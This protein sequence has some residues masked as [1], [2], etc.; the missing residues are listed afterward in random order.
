MILDSFKLYI[1]KMY[2]INARYKML[3]TAKDDY[4]EQNIVVIFPKEITYTTN[5]G[6]GI[7]GVELRGHLALYVTEDRKKEDFLFERMFIN[8]KDKKLN[9]TSN[10]SI[11]HWNEEVLEISCEFTY[12]EQYEFNKVERKL[13]EITFEV[14]NKE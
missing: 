2:G 12:L 1:L 4:Q 10:F 6:S 11:N 13:K 8:Q 14:I 3:D 5:D 9:C 7:L